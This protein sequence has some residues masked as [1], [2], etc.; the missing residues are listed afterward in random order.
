MCGVTMQCFSLP[1]QRRSNQV[2][3]VFVHLSHADTLERLAS[4]KSSVQA[5]MGK[6]ERRCA[7]HR[8]TLSDLKVQL[9]AKFGNNINL[10]ADEDW[11][12][13]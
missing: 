11:A 7:D 4:A 3:E 6:L 10:E 12:A 2:G 5:E 1:W 13:A 8:Q 9:Y